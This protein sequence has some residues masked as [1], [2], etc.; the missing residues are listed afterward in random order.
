MSL[1]G[2]R[3]A[4]AR[5]LLAACAVLA[6]PGDVLASCLEPRAPMCAAGDDNFASQEEFES[7]R[8]AMESYKADVEDFVSCL[9]DQSEDAMTSYREAL[10]SFSTRAG[11]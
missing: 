11:N 6:A 2:Y 8:G 4:R 7:C 5:A 9:Q 3:S 10:S 1:N